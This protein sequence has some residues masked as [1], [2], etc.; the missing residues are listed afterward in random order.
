MSV[1]AEALLFVTLST[2]RMG[3]KRVRLKC[4]T[5]VRLCAARVVHARTTPNP[6]QRARASSVG[7]TQSF[8][9]C[10]VDMY[11]YEPSP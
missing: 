5:A 6:S 11:A 2:A 9:F 4:A 10:Q 1:N 7:K 3:G 8:G